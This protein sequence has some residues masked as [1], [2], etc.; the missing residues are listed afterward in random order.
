MTEHEKPTLDF[1]ALVS[2][3]WLRSKAFYINSLDSKVVI[4]ELTEQELSDYF[5][6]GRQKEGEDDKEYLKRLE[7]VE[8]S[9][10]G[11]ILCGR[12]NK[13]SPGDLKKLVKNLSRNALSEIREIAFDF[14]KAERRSMEEL[15]KKSGGSPSSERTSE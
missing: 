11:R 3:P 7:K 2:K 13:P 14:N 8:E 5:S 12:D 6:A 1:A 10:I 4:H 9:F 15:E